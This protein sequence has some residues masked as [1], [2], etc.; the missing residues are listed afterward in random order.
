MFRQTLLLLLVA[1]TAA[2][3]VADEF[4][5]EFRNQTDRKIRVKTVKFDNAPPVTLNNGRGF[6]LNRV[7]QSGARRSAIYAGDGNR[8]IVVWDRETEQVLAMRSEDL[9]D[10]FDAFV[11]FQE[12]PTQAGEYLIAVGAL[13]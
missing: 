6:D 8:V 12:H 5:V 2:P 1:G 3:A 7:G 13:P 4:R 10:D 11:A 9:T